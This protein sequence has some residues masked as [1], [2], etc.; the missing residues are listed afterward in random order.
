LLLVQLLCAEIVALKNEQNPSVRRLANLADVEAGITAAF[1]SGGFFFADI[2]NN[3]VDAAGLA[4][5]RF[6]AALG[7]GAIVTR[8]A[9][10]QEF[11]EVGESNLD[12]LLQRQLIEE[13]GEEYGFRWS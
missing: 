3:Q 6:I 13:V 7:E 8:K 5:L 4:I 1:S 10:L 9:L 11:P 12:L 2:Q